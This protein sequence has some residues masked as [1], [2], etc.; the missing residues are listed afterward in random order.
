MKSFI[1]ARS[2][3]VTE[4]LDGFLSSTPNTHLGRLDGYPDTKVVLRTDWD[5][6]GVALISGGGS[7]HEPAHA[8]FVGEGMLTAAVSGEVFASPSVEAVLSAILAVGGDPGVL[9]IVKNYTGDRLNFGLAAERARSMGHEVETVIVADDIAIPDSHQARGVAGTLLVHKIAGFLAAEGASLSTVSEVARQAASECV[10]IGLS[11]ETCT[12]P[13]TS[14]QDYLSADEVELG[15]GIHGEPGTS[16]IPHGSADE[17]MA[18]VCDRLAASIPATGPRYAVL[19]NNLGAVPGL[20][21]S[22]LARSFLQSAIGERVD[23]IVG[24]APM[25]TSLDMK[26]FSLS[27]LPLDDRR[28]TALLAPVTAPGWPGARPV[29]GPATVPMPVPVV[30]D[31]WVPSTDP[32]VRK[33][34]VATCEALLSAEDELNALDARTGDG[35]A[36]STFAL[37]ARAVTEELDRLPFADGAALASAV[38]ET[39]SRKVGGSSGVLMAIM[40]AAAG[41]ALGSGNSLP[42][43]LMAGTRRMMRYGGAEVGDRTM[44]DALIPAVRSLVDGGSFSEAADAARRG[45]DSTTEM[46]TARAGR[47]AHVN[48]ENLRGV[49][50]PGAEAVARIFEA[51]AAVVDPTVES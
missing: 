7:G 43:S 31:R 34:T 37:A 15:L 49:T 51:V 6:S 30:T 40:L 9:L 27:L 20:E 12:I 5:R 36:G 38:S 4:A 21:M 14:R 3:L 8:G 19:V 17:L 10:S 41:E 46:Q 1:N 16:R 45:A 42:A 11:L 50:D 35:D 32:T 23:L 22:I 33:A 25:M 29:G 26:G 44:L 39:L 18:I 24:P 47:S 28:R 2:D 13:G 48:P